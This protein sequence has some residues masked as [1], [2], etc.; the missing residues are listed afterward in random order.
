MDVSEDKDL[1]HWE[2][3]DLGMSRV[4]LSAWARA[5]HTS[6]QAGRDGETGPPENVETDDDKS[7]LN[8]E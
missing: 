8:S 1:N 7:S 6:G 3:N 5:E 4:W 2:H